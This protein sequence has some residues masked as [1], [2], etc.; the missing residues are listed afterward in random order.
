[1]TTVRARHKLPGILSP[2]EVARLL[3]AAP[4]VKYQAALGVACGAGL[5]ASEVVS[6]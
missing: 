2:D 5:R 3:D 6:L 1:M 4:G